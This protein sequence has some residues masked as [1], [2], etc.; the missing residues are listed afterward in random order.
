MPFEIIEYM[1][2][3]WQS[4]SLSIWQ[5]RVPGQAFGQGTLT[6]EADTQTPL[7][8]PSSAHE[9]G[10]PVG[11]V[12]MPHCSLG[13]TRGLAA[14]RVAK[15][16]AK[17]RA[18][19]IV[20]TGFKAVAE[21]FLRINSMGRPL[22]VSDWSRLSDASAGQ[23][24]SLMRNKLQRGDGG[25]GIR[26]GYPLVQALW[27]IQRLPRNAGPAVMQLAE[28]D[29]RAN[30]FTYLASAIRH[31]VPFRYASGFSGMV[32]SLFPPTTNA[33]IATPERVLAC[34]ISTKST[35]IVCPPMFLEGFTLPLQLA[36]EPAN[37]IVRWGPARPVGG[38]CSGQE[39]GN[40]DGRIRNAYRHGW[41]YFQFL[42]SLEP[43]LVPVDVDTTGWLFQLIVRVPPASSTPT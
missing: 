6:M 42:A 13:A 23:W 4:P 2:T 33:V 22:V 37:L 7:H 5:F 10:H 27:K 29:I 12:Q 40:I 38:R 30:N 21:V 39:W 43:V 26:I 25:A 1:L 14:A 32:I 9:P 24:I 17:R 31:G 3:G 41:E 8:R 35:A 11:E 19:Y 20:K 36:A 15:T 28:A 16:S 18:A 34:A